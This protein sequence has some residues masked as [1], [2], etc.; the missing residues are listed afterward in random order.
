MTRYLLRLGAGS[1]APALTESWFAIN[2]ECDAAINDGTARISE[3]ELL[4]RCRSSSVPVLVVHGR[5][6]PRPVEALDALCAA[7][8]D[9]QKV[10]LDGVG[11]FPWLEAPGSFDDAIRPFLE[12]TPVLAEHSRNPSPR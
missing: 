4:Q 2:H 8:P 11:H 5:A 1:T 12:E 9:I 6:D 3:A 10:V 7:L